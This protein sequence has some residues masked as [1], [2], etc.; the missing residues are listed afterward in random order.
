MFGWVNQ[1][2]GEIKRIKNLIE[3]I[4]YSI[5]VSKISHKLPEFKLTFVPANKSL[6]YLNSGLFKQLQAIVN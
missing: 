4:N 2:S 5:Q 1:M 3:V 6:A